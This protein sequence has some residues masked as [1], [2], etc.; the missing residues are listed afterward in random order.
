MTDVIFYNYNGKR[1]QLSKTFSQGTN[2]KCTF[3]AEYNLINPSIKISNLTDFDYNYCYIPSVNRYYFIDRKIL[4][5]NAFYELYLTIDVLQTYYNSIKIMSG[6]VVRTDTNR[7]YD[8]QNTSIPVTIVPTFETYSFE[9][10]FN[11]DG[12]N[13][14][15]ATGYLS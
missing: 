1:N 3:N 15:L 13:V 10:K 2:I 12:V 9:N 7:A 8:Y 5:R 6:T 14:L 4:R 11:S